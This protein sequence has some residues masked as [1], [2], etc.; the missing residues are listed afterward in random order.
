MGNRRGAYRFLVGKPK[1]NNPLRRPRRRWGI[2][3]EKRTST[4]TDLVQHKGKLWV[5]VKTL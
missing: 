5:F 3:L 1:V 2:I 4:G